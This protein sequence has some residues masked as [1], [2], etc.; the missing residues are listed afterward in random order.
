VAFGCH[1]TPFLFAFSP[2][3][4]R[5]RLTSVARV[6]KPETQEVGGEGGEIESTLGRL[7]CS[8]SVNESLLAIN[9]SLQMVAA[10]GRRLSAVL[11]LHP[12]CQSSNGRSSIARSWT[13]PFEHHK[14]SCKL[15]CRA[16]WDYFHFTSFH[17]ITPVWCPQRRAPPQLPRRNE[18]DECIGMLEPRYQY[19]Q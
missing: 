11:V 19:I 8:P 9:Y 14:T 1:A 5:V 15:C 6:R 10:S 4:S 13:L 18:A 16:C 3:V 17:D 2:I 12:S 7:C